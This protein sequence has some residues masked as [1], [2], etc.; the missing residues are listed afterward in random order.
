[1]TTLLIGVV[2]LVG[3]HSARPL[4]PG[5][6]QAAIAR[7]GP[8]AWKGVYSVVSLAGIWLV[9]QGYP[10]ARAAAT[11]VWEPPAALRHLG[12]ALT[13]PAFVMMVAAYVPGNAIRARLGHPM[14]LGVKTW[15]F[16]HLLANG[17]SVSMLLFGIALVWAVLLFRS[18][19][20][21]APAA[22]GGS[23]AAATIAAVVVGVTLWIGFAF[24]GHAW[25]IGVAP[26][27]M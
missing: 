12:A 15:A 5:L 10:E 24:W 19:R 26:F 21:E 25:L 17:D 13:L 8:L 16:A 27:G 11:V 18:L 6:R 3:M 7:I 2:L 23:S 1:M 4:Y 22:G 9:V 20:R 14:T